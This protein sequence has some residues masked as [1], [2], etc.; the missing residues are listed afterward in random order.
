MQW[1]DVVSLLGGYKNHA[2]PHK[3]EPWTLDGKYDGANCLDIDPYVIYEKGVAIDDP[4][5]EVA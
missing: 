2:M 5:A 4:L 3:I 1:R